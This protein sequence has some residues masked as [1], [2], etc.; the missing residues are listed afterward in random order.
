MMDAMESDE[1]EQLAERELRV[2]V[3]FL[4]GVLERCPQHTAVMKALADLYTAV[5]E[6]AR[7]LQ[8]DEQLV[9]CCRDD[10]MVW[11]NLSCSYA[12]DGQLDAAIAALAQSV[13]LGYCDYD[14]AGRDGD[15]DALRKDARFER[16]LN[17]M[18]LQS[19]KLV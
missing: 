13:E 2:E 17:R 5:G 12:L 11:Y 18:V 3:N 6:V 16:L 8:L 19:K 15:L 9:V 10:E 7:G 1:A 14:W 4:A